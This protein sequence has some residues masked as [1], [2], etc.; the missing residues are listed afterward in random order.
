MTLVGG[1]V[2]LPR[3]VY[4]QAVAAIEAEGAVPRPDGLFVTHSRLVLNDLVTHVTVRARGGPHGGSRARTVTRWS[5]QEDADVLTVAVSLDLTDDPPLGRE[6]LDAA[7]LP[8][9]EAR[10]LVTGMPVQT[11]GALWPTHAAEFGPAM[12]KW[13]EPNMPSVVVLVR[14]DRGDKAKAVQ[15][16]ERA[17]P[18]PMRPVVTLLGIRQQVAGACDDFLADHAIARLKPETV[19]VL[20]RRP[21][22]LVE[23]HRIVAPG[24]R[25]A[26]QLALRVQSALEQVATDLGPFFDA[27]TLEVST[28]REP[29]GRVDDLEQQLAGSRAE[30]DR[31]EHLV[32]RLEASLT[33]ERSRIRELEHELGYTERPPSR[34]SGDEEGDAPGT[35]P[36]APYAPPTA[37]GEPVPD[38]EFAS[39]AELLDRVRAELDLVELGDAVTSAEEL[40]RHGKAPVWRSRTWHALAALQEYAF[41]RRDNGTT[42]AFRA[43]L[44]EHPDPRVSPLNVV[45]AETS[46][47]TSNA[48]LR[49]A[50]TFAVSTEVAPSGRAVF[51]AHIKLDRGQSN[52]LRL[53]YLDDTSGTGKVHIGYLGT[54]LPTRRRG[55]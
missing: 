39:F 29:A 26:R 24:R 37:P 48:G 19:C 28:D 27:A 47:T 22:E 8:T 6:V 16:A 50:R 34:P 36:D 51:G 2:R 7:G 15:Y 21:G 46:Y 54:H 1:V 45:P 31:M 32:E 4:E 13:L 55:G 49:Q 53:H 35:V 17:V 18:V 42:T 41:A 12:A 52:A 20:L 38:R 10:D 43:W 30:S 11:K 44:E 40:D 23:H 5:R 9:S 14:T 33:R 25:D 3:E